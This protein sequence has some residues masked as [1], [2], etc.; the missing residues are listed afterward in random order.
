MDYLNSNL[1]DDVYWYSAP[2]DVKQGLFDHNKVIKEKYSKY[3]AEVVWYLGGVDVSKD[4][5]TIYDME[6]SDE[7][8]E[9][10][11]SYPFG[12]PFVHRTREWLG[13]VA[14]IYYSD[15]MY[16]GG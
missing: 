9:R 2:G 10:N 5:S 12:V 13:K 11:D 15:Y 14:L 7:N 8:C 4:L 3:I 16:L 1:S 6:R